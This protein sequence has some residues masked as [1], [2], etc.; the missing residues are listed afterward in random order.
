MIVLKLGHNKAEAFCL[1][2][3]DITAMKFNSHAKFVKFGIREIVN[4]L[5]HII[6]NK[7][8]IVQ[9]SLKPRDLGKVAF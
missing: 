8:T 2:F 9:T 3:G 1:V 7:I 6:C 4:L 5:Y